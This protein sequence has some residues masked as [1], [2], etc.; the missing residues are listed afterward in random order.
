MQDFETGDYPQFKSEGGVVSILSLTS[1]NKINIKKK[2]EKNL[3]KIKIF[4]V[5]WFILY[6]FA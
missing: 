3:K 6:N 4:L 1:T 5:M 2:I